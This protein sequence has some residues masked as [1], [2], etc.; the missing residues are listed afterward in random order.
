MSVGTEGTLA[1]RRNGRER[2]HY[3]HKHFKIFHPAGVRHI[4]ISYSVCTREVSLAQ[5]LEDFVQLRLRT[6]L[7]NGNV[8][9]SGV[10]MSFT[11]AN[12]A[13]PDGLL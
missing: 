1:K 4:L 12:Y 10:T 13:F 2:I 8:T 9:L 5:L 6:H 11:Q 3:R 7:S